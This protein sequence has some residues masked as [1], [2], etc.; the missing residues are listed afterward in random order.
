[1]KNTKM[2]YRPLGKTGLTA[3]AIGLGTEHLDGKPFETVDAVIHAALE[4]GINIMDVFMPGDDIREKI[5][6]ALKGHREEVILQGHI[7]ST[8]VRA[9][10]SQSRDYPTIKKY[11]EALLRHLHTDYIDFGMIFYIDNEADYHTAFD[12][13][14]MRY[15]Q[16]LKQEGKIR[17]IGMSSHNP[18]IAKKV[19]ESG[20]IDLL[21]FSIN[22]AFD[23]APSK[24]D[25]L[26]HMDDDKTFAYEKTLDPARADLYKTCARLGVAITVMKTFGAGKL[27][28]PRFTPFEKPL[29]PVQCVHYALSRPGVCSALVGCASVAELDAALAYLDATDAEKDYSAV[30][31]KYQGCFKGSCVYCSH[32]LPCP[33]DINIAEVNRL[34]DIALLDEANIPA[35]VFERYKA[36][37]HTASECQECGSCEEKCPFS[38]R[39][40]DR[41]RKAAKLFQR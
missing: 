39:V 22:P 30:I 19:V 13:D 20:A 15:A 9:Q 24:L 37:S 7:G 2:L 33:A 10:Y 34:L 25:V 1:M 6:R 12:G 14:C 28:D 8:D 17:H 3:S 23:M 4:R 11:F 5:G 36:L 21:L 41:M 18:L 32:C 26:E 27:L 31:E 38:V 16:E 40:I 29:T 35:S